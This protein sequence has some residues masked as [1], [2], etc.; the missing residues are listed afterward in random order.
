[1]PTN[2]GLQT[3]SPPVTPL[4]MQ[5]HRIG[6]ICSFGFDQH[7]RKLEE[8]QGRA[9]RPAAETNVRQNWKQR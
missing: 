6:L 5:S 3:D 9:R 4:A 7:R 8:S 2:K 1:M